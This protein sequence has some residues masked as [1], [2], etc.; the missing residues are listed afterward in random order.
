M[1]RTF[2]NSYVHKLRSLFNSK[3][4]HRPG[5]SAPLVSKETGGQEI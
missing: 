4:C 5:V 1:L 2:L 3:L